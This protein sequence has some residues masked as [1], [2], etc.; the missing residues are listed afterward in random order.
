MFEH[1][2]VEVNQ[3][4]SF[5]SFI[6]SVSILHDNNQIFIISINL[7]QGKRINLFMLLRKNR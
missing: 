2:F 6:W 1:E 3:I 4:D 7:V 5:L